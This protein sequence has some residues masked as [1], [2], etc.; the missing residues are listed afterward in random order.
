MLSRLATV[1]SRIAAM[2]R[3][4]ATVLSRLAAMLRGTTAVLRRKRNQRKRHEKRCNDSDH[5]SLLI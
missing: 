2:L 4:L 1:L 5:D 3:R